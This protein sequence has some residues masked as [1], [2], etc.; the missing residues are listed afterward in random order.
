MSPNRTIKES[1]TK[2]KDTVNKSNDNSFNQEKADVSKDGDLF[3]KEVKK[4]DPFD[5]EYENEDPFEETK[6][7][8]IGA[9]KDPFAETAKVDN[10]K[11]KDDVFENSGIKSENN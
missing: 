11:D 9:T 5:D 8:S 3:S 7:A 2:D 1:V 4:D 6:G 10:L